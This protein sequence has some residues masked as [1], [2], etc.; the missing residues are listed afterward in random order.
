M[1]SASGTG[2]CAS[3]FCSSASAGGHEEQ[4]SEVNSSTTTTGLRPASGG[5][6]WAFA[7][8][9]R[10]EQ[11]ARIAKDSLNAAGN[12]F[13]AFVSCLWNLIVESN[14]CFYRKLRC[15]FIRQRLH[16]R[17]WQSILTIEV[18]DAFDYAVLLVFSEFGKHGQGQH[19]FC[20]ALGFGEVTFAVSEINEAR[21]Q[22][23]RDRIVNLRS[24]LA[25]GEELAQ[26]LPAVGADDILMENMM[27]GRRRMRQMDGE[28]VWDC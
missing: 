25:R 7:M 21:L 19:F 26:F 11:A 1:I 14:A 20:G 2:C 24:N 10:T 16:D 13:I 18:G 17:G 3:S 27:S 15:R 8:A 12:F 6:V 23:Q 22:V 4:P 9:A 28:V 5:E